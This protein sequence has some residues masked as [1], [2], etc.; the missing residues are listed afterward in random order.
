MGLNSFRWHC[1]LFLLVE[2]PGLLRS[3]CQGEPSSLG[4]SRLV[5]PCSGNRDLLEKGDV[6]ETTLAFGS[7]EFVYLWKPD[8]CN[9]V[10]CE[11]GMHIGVS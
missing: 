6:V 8:N 10:L 2:E 3:C 4:Q 7:D 1:C 5:A 11:F 9:V